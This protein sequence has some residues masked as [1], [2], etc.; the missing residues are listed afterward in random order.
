MHTEKRMLIDLEKSFWQSMVDEDTETAVSMLSEPAMMVSPHGAMKFD[1]DGYRRMASHGSMVL[2]AFELSDMD[3]LFPAEDTA[4][5]TYRARQS[6]AIRGGSHHT[7]Q[8]MAD[9]STWVR[10]EGRWQCVMHT[11]TPV[12]AEPE[13]VAV[14][15]ARSRTLLRHEA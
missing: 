14:E 10:K 12:P 5:L 8:E 7:T 9:S 15:L 13:P 4:V 6:M 2:K 3:V 11:E 1:H